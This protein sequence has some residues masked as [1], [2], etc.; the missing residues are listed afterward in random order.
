MKLTPGLVK[1]HSNFS[2][3]S[4]ISLQSQSSMHEQ[5]EN[6]ASKPHRRQIDSNNNIFI[7]FSHNFPI[8]LCSYCRKISPVLALHRHYYWRMLKQP[9]CILSVLHLLVQLCNCWT[10]YCICLVSIC[11]PVPCS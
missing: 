11:G 3:E 4:I 9:V 7:F 5:L 10:Y 6:Y 2:L 8:Y 1:L